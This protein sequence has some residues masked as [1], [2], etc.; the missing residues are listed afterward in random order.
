MAETTKRATKPK[1]LPKAPTSKPGS[2][3]KNEILEAALRV[4]AQHSFEGA[5]LQEIAQKASIGQPLVHYHFGSKEN[6]WKAAVDYALNDLKS[7]YQTVVVTTVDL[8]PIDVIRVLCRSFLNFSA[9]CPEHALIMINEM[10][11]PGDRFEWLTEKYLKPIHQHLDSI[12]EAAKKKGQI[13]DI[14]VVHLTNTIFISLVHFFTI[15]PL[16]RGERRSAAE[17]A[18]GEE[19]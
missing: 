3:S 5:A 4:F 14:P 1:R 11:V 15:A 13:R 16:L 7:F 19:H 18:M 12:L 2:D 6:L 8:E 9:Q 10:R 17:F